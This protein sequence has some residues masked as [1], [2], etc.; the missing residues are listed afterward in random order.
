MAPVDFLRHV[1]DDAVVV[2][3]APSQREINGQPPGGARHT[4]HQRHQAGEPLVGGGVGS[5]G[6]QDGPYL[7]QRALGI[8]ADAGQ[9][10]GQGQAPFNGITVVAAAQLAEQPL[11]DLIRRAAAQGKRRGSCSTG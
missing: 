11:H 6:G 1:E 10:P 2:G 7:G 4:V 3:D 9:L 8:A 5:G